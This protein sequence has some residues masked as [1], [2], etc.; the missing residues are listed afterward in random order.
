MQHCTL[1]IIPPAMM[2]SSVNFLHSVNPSANKLH[3]LKRV[4]GLEPPPKQRTSDKAALQT[5][6]PAVT[7]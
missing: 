1:G 4:T 5:A 6:P 7:V 2:P 3:P